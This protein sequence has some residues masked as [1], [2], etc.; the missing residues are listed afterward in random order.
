[1]EDILQTELVEN[2]EDL[3]NPIRRKVATFIIKNIREAASQAVDQ[4]ACPMSSGQSLDA[5]CT[6]LGLSVEYAM[7]LNLWG[8]A[9]EPGQAYT[10][11]MRSICHNIKGNANLRDRLLGGSLSPIELSQMSTNDMMSKE[12]KEESK[13]MIEDAEKQAMLVQ[14]VGPRIRRTHKGEELVGDG[15]PMVSDEPTTYLQAPR[16]TIGELAAGDCVEQTTPHSPHAVELPPDVGIHPRS[17]A[18]ARLPKIDTKHR[19]RPSIGS[20]RK[21]SATFD[22]Q[23]VWSSVDSPGLEK[24]QTTQAYARP[25]VTPGIGV[26]ADPEIDHLLKDEDQDEEEPYSPTDYQMDAS[27]IWRGSLIMPTVAEFR[28]SAK[29]A[30]GANLSA[31]Y[32][33]QRLMTSALIVE[34][35]IATNTASAYVCGLQYSKTSDVSVVAITPNESA[36]DQAQF[37]KLFTYFIERDRWG[38]V[39]SSPVPQVRDI[40]IVPLEAGTAPKPEFIEL[41]EES[42]VEDSRSGRMLLVLYVIKTTPTPA[43]APQAQPYVSVPAS[44]GSPYTPQESPN[45]YRTPSIPQH[46]E[47]M[48]PVAGSPY[49]APSQQTPHQPPQHHQLQLQL[50]LQLQQQQPTFSS[51]ELTGYEAARFVLGSLADCPAVGQLLAQCP[52]TGVKEFGHVRNILEHTPECRTNFELLMQKTQALIASQP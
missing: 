51:F 12:L 26:K 39:G 23:N 24:H 45:Y 30:A 18:A 15:Q 11:Q 48:S 20:G 14:E 40:Y 52:G 32:P 17:P 5:F 29:Y 36:D 44:T 25:S 16:R 33:W 22:I 34:G 31:A 38:V 2:V 6:K 43:P 7:C 50:Q 1:M 47:H 46:P 10:A 28:G 35:R 3:H 21:S 8:T 13:K 41:L 4:G 42:S 49:S 19:S 9:G 27:T 37:D